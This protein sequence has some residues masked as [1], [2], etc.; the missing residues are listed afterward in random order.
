[1]RRARPLL[2]TLVDIQASGTD[3]APAIEAAFAVIAEV[4]R[5]MSFHEPDSDVSRINCSPAGVS[6]TVSAHTC[7]VLRF[8]HQLSEMSRGRFDVCIGA[9]MV[10]AGLLPTPVGAA[11]PT[12]RASYL[13]LELLPG[14]Q[15]K[16]VKSVWIDVGG[17][18]KGYAVDCA[19][20]VLRNYCLDSAVV[21]AGGDLRFFGVPQAVQ[22]RDPSQPGSL[23][24]L[25]MLEDCAVA[26]SSGRYSERNIDALVDKDTH[27]C[28]RWNQ[29]ISVI[30]PECMIADAL[31][32]VVR[33]CPEQAP[34]ILEH[35][36]AEAVC[37]GTE[38][39]I[40]QPD[41]RTNN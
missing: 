19:I 20:Q 26:S 11:P 35:F 34:K 30:A 10:R 22:I 23:Y 8:A 14:R 5:L 16:A 40:N 27:A 32:K 37:I 39:H 25:G 1:M 9:E 33:L 3:A 13:D 6:L 24:S 36:S 15:V 21:N 7:A 41:R 38:Q 12:L 18:A 31:T 17:V 28:L 4:H 29:S 2:G